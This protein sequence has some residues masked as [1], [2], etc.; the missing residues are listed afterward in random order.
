MRKHRG[1]WTYEKYNE[2]A[3]K[4]TNKRDF[5]LL[6]SCAYSAAKRHGF[7]FTYEAIK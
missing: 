2:I 4:Y 5:R 1:Y 3:L 7:M 6:D